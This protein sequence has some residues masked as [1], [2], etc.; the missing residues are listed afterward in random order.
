MEDPFIR[1][2]EIEFTLSRVIPKY[3][4]V[5][6]A[7]EAYQQDYAEYPQTL[8]NLVPEYLD[9]VPGIYI[10]KGSELSY[11][12]EPYWEAAASFTFYITGHYPG[13]ASMHGWKLLYCPVEFDRCNTEGDRHFREFRVNDD[14]IWINESAL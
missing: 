10:R 4:K 12:P 14:W 5:I 8:E 1:Q 7:I 9:E 13:L 6:W 11:K 2:R 3:D